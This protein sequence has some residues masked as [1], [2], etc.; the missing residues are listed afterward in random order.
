MDHEFR[1]CF[2]SRR[3]ISLQL[4]EPAEF[5]SIAT[6]NE[7]WSDFPA[8]RWKA[9]RTK[10]SSAYSADAALPK[11]GSVLGN[12][13]IL[14]DFYVYEIVEGTI[15]RLFIGQREP[16]VAEIPVDAVAGDLQVLLNYHHPGEM[17]P[18]GLGNRV[19]ELLLSAINE[20]IYS[21][22]SLL[23]IPFHYIRNIP[24][25]ALSTF[26]HAVLGCRG[27]L[28][29]SHTCQ[30]LPSLSDSAILLEP[31][32]DAFLWASIRLMKLM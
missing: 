7:L 27:V 17:A 11:S 1:P 28:P 24:F 26:C 20:D 32:E 21:A 9:W 10:I 29:V 4:A 12:R 30:V 8:D 22:D 6:E 31:R 19:D 14:A 13:G 18:E 16:A 3:I 25:H 15:V 23:I 5:S 2:Q